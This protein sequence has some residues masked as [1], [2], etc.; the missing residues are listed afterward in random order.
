MVVHLLAAAVV[1]FVVLRIAA[2]WSVDRYARYG[3]AA[4][5]VAALVV[6]RLAGNDG[7]IAAYWAVG[8]VFAVAAH[9]WLTRRRRPSTG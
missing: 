9:D 5:G 2:Q 6:S 1:T 3:L 4:I 8:F 7:S